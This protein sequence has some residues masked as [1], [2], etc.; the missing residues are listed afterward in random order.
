MRRLLVVA[1]TLAV[2]TLS[3]AFTASAATQR[4]DHY[5]ALGDSY[6]AGPLIP[7]QRIDPIGCLRSTSNYPAQLALRLLVRSFTDVSCSGADT[8][9]MTSPQSIPLGTNPPQFNALKPDTDLV[10]LGIGGNDSSVFGTL[11]GT[12][13]GLRASD[14]TGNPCQR[15]FTVDGV[16]TIKAKIA[17]TQNNIAAVLTE[18]HA[19]SPHAKVLAVGYPRIAPP[20]GTCPGILPF[21]DGD[22]AWLNSV[23]E[24]L[25]GAISA[26]AAADGK[27]SYVDTFTPSLGHDAC[28]A[29]PW[30]NGQNNNLLAAAAYHPFFAGMQGMAQASY[31]SLR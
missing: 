17:Q 27:T 11:V 3:S 26:A 25:N 4:F 22:Y 1:I 21:A 19:R 29:S 24:A 5:V 30:I 12:C 9:N 20:S 10:T 7:L 8:S 28:S 16:D 13:P 18:I 2:I 31:A 14:P 15:Q 6:T 23:E